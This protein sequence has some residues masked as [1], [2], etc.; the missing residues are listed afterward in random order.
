[1]HV[2]DDHYVQRALFGKL[3]QQ[4]AEQLVP[5]GPGLAQA[6]ELAAELAGQVE[7]RPE[8]AGVT[9]VTRAPTTTGRQSEFAQLVDQRRFR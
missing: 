3:V 6:V 4:G 1:V 5:P 9:A 8:R 2:L 7:Q